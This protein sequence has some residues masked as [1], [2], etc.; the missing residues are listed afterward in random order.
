MGMYD[1]PGRRG[2][3]KLGQDADYLIDPPD[4]GED[5]GR[6]RGVGPRG[7]AP[8]ELPPP[9]PLPA[10]QEEARAAVDDLA[11]EL[12]RETGDLFG[13]SGSVRVGWH[14]LGAPLP[15]FA[16]A[17]A[18]VDN[19]VHVSQRAEQAGAQRVMELADLARAAVVGWMRS[20]GR[21][22]RPLPGTTSA[23]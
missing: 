2:F 7:A 11:R 6:Y 12:E 8:V 20:K 21:E 16:D 10:P 18:V 23:S 14:L 5:E 22:P 15:Q 17:Q 9:A 1:R 19:C 13:Y 4:E 3:G